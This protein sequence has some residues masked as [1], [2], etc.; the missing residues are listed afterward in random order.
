MKVTEL[1]LAA[2][3]AA[4]YTTLVVVPPAPLSFG[5]IQLRVADSLI[6]LSSMLGVPAVIGVSLGALIANTYY[7]LSPLDIIL[8]SLANLLAAY[9]IF[10]FKDRLLL[11]CIAASGI[12]GCIVGGYL[13]L[14]FPPPEIFGLSLP[15]WLSM[16][17]S[18][19]LSSLVAV[20][21]LGYGLINTLKASG[22]E[23]LL[24]SKGVATD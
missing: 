4:L 13:W 7:F 21:V 9:L 15:I 5:P 2:V 20:A 17:I 6:P 22:F 10:R 23:K 3:I 8:G 16:I 24:K 18:I 19:T 14:F 1:T 12:I 11:S